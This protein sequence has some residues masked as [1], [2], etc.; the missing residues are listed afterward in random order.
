M[1]GRARDVWVSYLRVSTPEQAAST[2]VVQVDVHRESWHVEHEQIESGAALQDQSPLEERM[3]SEPLKQGKQA[4]HFPDGFEHKAG[5]GC[6]T[7]K[8]NLGHH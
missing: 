2:D 7:N 1:S 4:L 5:F 8:I 6:S 3:A